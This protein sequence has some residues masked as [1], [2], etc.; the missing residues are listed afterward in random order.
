MY[1]TRQLRGHT[2][3][4]GGARFHLSSIASS[5]PRAARHFEKKKKMFSL[6]LRA[7][8]D[9]RNRGHPS[10]RESDTYR[11]DSARRSRFNSPLS[12]NR[13]THRCYLPRKKKHICKMAGGTHGPRASISGRV[14][15]KKKKKKKKRV[16]RR[17]HRPAGINI[18]SS[19]RC[20]MLAKKYFRLTHGSPAASHFNLPFFVDSACFASKHAPVR[21]IDSITSE[22][23]RIY[24]APSVIMLSGRSIGSIRSIVRGR[25]SRD[26]SS[27]IGKCVS[28][29]VNA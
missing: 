7:S 26:S 25:A 5:F 19:S 6:Y 21:S 17:A 29:P 22:I 1:F 11:A 3:T 15:K 2:L 12:S 4:R 20:R 27:E 8:A 18:S 10:C 16:S 9:S 28:Y 23:T 24:V 14:P 13:L